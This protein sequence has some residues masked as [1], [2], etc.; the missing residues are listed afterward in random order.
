MQKFKKM[1]RFFFQTLPMHIIF[2]V[3]ALLPNSVPTIRLRGFLISPFFKSCGK[4]FKIASGVVIN[5]PDKI[6]IGDDVFIAHNGWINGVGGLV[7]ENNVLIGPLCV[8]VTSKHVTNGGKISLK[9]ESAPVRIESN[10]WLSSHV[11]VTDG[12]VIEKNSIIGAGAVVTK[13]I[14]PNSKVGGV[15]AKSLGV[16]QYE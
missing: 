14:P 1:K 8:I 5:N 4:N 16:N 3:T 7:I 13:S 11:V 2:L 9:S 12:I 6:E 10:C 15:P